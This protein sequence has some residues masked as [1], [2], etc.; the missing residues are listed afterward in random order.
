[1]PIYAGT[2]AGGSLPHGR[3][4]DEIA[5]LHGAG[6]PAAEALGSSSWLARDWLGRP[7]M[8]EGAP[9]DFF[10]VDDDPRA[11]FETLRAP[12]AVVLNGVVY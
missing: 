12:R 6:L 4:V 3:I 5:A 1:V 2:D 8:E 10:V 11:D 9:A 7:S